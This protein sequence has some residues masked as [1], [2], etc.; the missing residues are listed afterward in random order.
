MPTWLRST[1][2]HTRSCHY[3]KYFLGIKYNI[4]TLFLNCWFPFVCQESNLHAIERRLNT[5]FASGDGNLKLPLNQRR[6]GIHNL[7]MYVLSV[8][9]GGGSCLIVPK[10]LRYYYN[11]CCLLELQRCLA[12]CY[13][14]GITAIWLGLLSD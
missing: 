1:W 11:F 13:L 9:P 3:E 14:H 8:L 6:K 12:C 2:D 10:L 4:N 5:Y 7:K